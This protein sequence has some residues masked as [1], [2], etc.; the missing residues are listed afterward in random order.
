MFIKELG[1]EVKTSS[2]AF[3]DI[4]AKKGIVTGYFS[5]FNNKDSDGDI[6]LPG[7][8]AKSIKERGPKSAQ[9][10][11]KHLLDHNRTKAVA[12]LQ[13]LKED[14]IGLQYESKAGRHTNGQDWILMCED[15]I[16]TEH[17]VGFETIKDERKDNINYLME[18]ILW[19]GSSLQGWGANANTPITGIKELKLTELSDRFVLIE[20][21]IR[22]GKY[23]DEA[24]PHLEKELKAI[25]YLLQL[26]TLDTTKP[27]H[28]I[29]TTLPGLKV[30]DLNNL[31][32]LKAAQ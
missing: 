27:D 30:I 7:F 8:F 1:F 19:E 25:K 13:D 32:T 4:D 23:S 26:L 28:P 3:K 12:V 15:G 20:K 29:D 17:S 11:V 16:I 21:C 2:I 9:P 6:I 18:G 10:R 31:F 14:N 22:N 5:A 24:F